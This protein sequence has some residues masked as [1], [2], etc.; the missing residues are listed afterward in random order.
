MP[1]LTDMVEQQLAGNTLT[2]MSKRLGAEPA[3][4]QQ[5]ISVTLPLLMGGLASNASRPDG[6]HALDTALEQDH[7]GGVLNDLGS[8][9]SNPEAFSAAGILGH[10]L[11]GKQAPVAQGVGRATGLS[12]Q[13]VTQL[14]MMLA[15]IVMG[16]LGR[17]KRQQKLDSGQL[18]TVLQQEHA[19]MEQRS[20]G[21][22]S[23]LGGLD[24]DDDGS[25]ADDIA[26]LGQ[27]MLGGLFGK[28]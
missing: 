24:R 8:L 14:L 17:Q 26:R 22:G 15:P 25:V 9:V 12:A 16:V 27:G 10:I 23:L 3:T 28:R 1:S 2:D 5:A 20:P 4:V 13:Q 19:H 7:D 18:G 11:R 21:A 6:A